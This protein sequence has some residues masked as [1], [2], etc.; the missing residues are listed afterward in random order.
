MFTTKLAASAPEINIRKGNTKGQLA[1]RTIPA[2]EDLRS[3]LTFW[4]PNA[5]LTYLFPGCHRN[6]HWK[7]LHCDSA[8][9]ILRAACDRIGLEGVSTHSFRRTALTL[10][11]NAGIPL[12]VIQ[13]VSGHRNLDQLQRYLDVQPE[14]I[15]GAVSALSVLTPSQA[16]SQARIIS[17][18]PVETEALAELGKSD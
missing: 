7:H 4:Y 1:T 11:S 6:H 9:K 14:Q 13:K 16:P 15:R 18:P 2:I 8:D 17:F 5:G 12:R 10:M 3:L